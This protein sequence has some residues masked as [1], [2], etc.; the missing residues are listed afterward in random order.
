MSVASDA[1]MDWEVLDPAV[2]ADFAA[3]ASCEFCAA[4][5]ELVFLE[6]GLLGDSLQMFKACLPS[7]SMPASVQ[8]PRCQKCTVES[9]S[10]ARLEATVQFPDGSTSVQR[11]CWDHAACLCLEMQNGSLKLKAVKRLL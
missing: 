10:A 11:V 8:N 6:I 5:A 1:A 3:A 2:P 7:C 9:G 4:P